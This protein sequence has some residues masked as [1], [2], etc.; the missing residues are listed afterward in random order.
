MRGILFLA[1]ADERGSKTSRS[2]IISAEVF[3]EFVVV[4]VLDWADIDD[5]DNDGIVVATTLAIVEV[6][7]VAGVIVVVVMMGK[8]VSETVSFLMVD[9]TLPKFSCSGLSKREDT[10]AGNC[11]CSVGGTLVDGVVVDNQCASRFVMTL[12][13]VTFLVTIM[14]ETVCTLVSLL[15]FAGCVED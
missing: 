6:V 2:S 9:A 3:G 15:D 10:A 5:V 8:V 7:I 13:E 11:D 4:V 1:P 14:A 12:V